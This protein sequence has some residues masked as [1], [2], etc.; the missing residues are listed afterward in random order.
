MGLVSMAKL[1]RCR[2]SE[3]MATT[4]EYTA[5]CLDEACAYILAQVE[6]DKKPMFKREYKSFSDLYKR[7]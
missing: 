3:L 2:P 1:Y 7:L 4:D 5:F 6:Q